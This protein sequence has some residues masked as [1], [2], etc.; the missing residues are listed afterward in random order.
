MAKQD[1]YKLLDVTRNASE[2]DIQ[3]SLSPARHEI[4]SDRNPDDP[5]SSINSRNARRP[6]RSCATRK[7]APR[8]IS[9]ATQASRAAAAAAASARE[10]PSRYLRRDVRRY[11]L[12]RPARPVA[13]FRGADL[14][15]ELELD[16]EQAV[17][18]TETEIQIPS[19]AECKTCKGPGRQGLGPKTCDTCTDRGRSGYSSRYSR[20]NSPAPAARGAA[21]SSA[22]PAIPA[23]GRAGCARR[24]PCP[25]RCRRVWTRATGSA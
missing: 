17:F 19:L 8:T 15:Y 7:S 25:S 9:S 22:I 3:E 23:S 2:A 4:P 14:R 20:F 18:G 6:M 21:R 13:G 16:L 5:E 10:K 12:G 11:F 1:Y 24:K